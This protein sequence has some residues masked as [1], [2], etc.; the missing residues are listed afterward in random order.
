MAARPPGGAAS[1]DDDRAAHA[2]A[3][4]RRQILEAAKEV[5][6]EAGY[7]EASINAI[8]ERAH[9]A[10]GTFYL[11][12]DG[13][14]A[15]FDALLDEAM[16]ELRARIT[17][18]DVEDPAAP[19]PH[20]QLRDGL[21][22]VLDYVLGDRLLATILLSG[23]TATEAEAANRAGAF[24]GE[25][26]SVIRTALEQGIQMKLVRP[27]NVEVTSAALLGLVRGVV[28]HLVTTASPPA[29]TEVVAEMI[30]V[31]LRGVLN[32]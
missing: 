12:F 15:V 31:A 2:R 16:R 3:E 17:R 28:E 19:P 26:R 20:L 13:K 7:H 4:R 23:T 11:Y 25:V 27:C 1:A 9:I 18:I 29:A 24:F 6:A 14:A 22:R 21:V 8:I 5:F 10:R 30:A 32:A